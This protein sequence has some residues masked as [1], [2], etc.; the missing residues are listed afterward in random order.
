GGL[1]FPVHQHR[2]GPLRGR[3][4]DRPLLEPHLPVSACDAARL[5]VSGLHR[6]RANATTRGSAIS[7]NAVLNPKAPADAPA[8]SGPNTNPRSP[9]KRNTPTAV[10]DRRSGATSESIAAGATAIVPDP[11]PSTP[12]MT[13]NTIALPDQP[14]ATRA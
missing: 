14:A 12:I 3:G 2:P 9:K 10:P 11:T 8:T 4:E 7:A 6:T 5:S 1:A 13:P